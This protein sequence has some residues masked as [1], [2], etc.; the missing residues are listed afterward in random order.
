MTK[1]KF[2]TKNFIDNALR[3]S[4]F[5]LAIMLSP[6]LAKPIARRFDF[7]GYTALRPMFTEIATVLLWGVEV[8]LVCLV[9]HFLKRQKATPKEEPPVMEE[10]R[11]PL[12]LK[13]VL[14][15][16][17][18]CAACIF[19]ISAII[20]FKVKPFYDIG[21]K[22]TGQKLYGELTRILKNVVKCLFIV[23][24]LG[25]AKAMASEVASAYGRGQACVWL[26]TGSILLLFG[27]VDVFASV[28]SYPLGVRGWLTAICYLCF[29]AAFTAVYYFTEENLVKSYLLI[30]L[31][32]IF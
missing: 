25:N 29:Y 32:Y 5:Y 26:L 20:G 4:L 19:A 13:N 28:V 7:L 18:L 1:P 3:F 11:A 22:V 14:I 10:K 24:M 12:P 23:A 9:A 17:L 30:V 31:I 15:L 21:E 16:S 8:G 6:L 27:V 2:L